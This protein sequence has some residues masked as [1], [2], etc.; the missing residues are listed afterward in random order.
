MARNRTTTKQARGPAAAPAPSAGSL[1]GASAGPVDQ[2]RRPEGPYWTRLDEIGDDA[3]ALRELDEHLATH[4]Y[5]EAGQLRT[6][7]RVALTPKA[8]LAA[9]DEELAAR[10]I[11]PHS[12]L[13][14]DIQTRQRRRGA[15]A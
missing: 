2:S 4:G 14:A 15:G 3:P 10:G 13:R 5:D 8:R 1:G 11:A 6:A 7:I 9:L 12:H